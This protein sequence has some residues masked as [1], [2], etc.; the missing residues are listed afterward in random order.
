MPFLTEVETWLSNGTTI[1][2]VIRSLATLKVLDEKNL[3]Y[4]VVIDN[5]QRAIEEENPSL[6]EDEWT[7]LEGRKGIKSL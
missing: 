3:K 1:D 7:Q 2:V 6:S 4:E 5:L